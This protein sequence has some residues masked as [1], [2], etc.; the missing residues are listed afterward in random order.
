MKKLTF[1][2][3]AATLAF[4]ASADV[5]PASAENCCA[6]DGFFFGLGV[7]AVDVG[8]KT[9]TTAANGMYYNDDNALTVITNAKLL[10]DV[11]FRT[12]LAR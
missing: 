5:E 10:G 11:L 4:G 9:E 2:I 12:I 3:F 8:V 6:Y 7:S 1:S